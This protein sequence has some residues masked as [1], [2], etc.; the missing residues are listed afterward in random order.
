MKYASTIEFGLNKATP[1]KSDTDADTEFLENATFIHDMEAMLAAVVDEMLDTETP[2]MQ[3][4][5]DKKCSY[6]EFNLIC[7]RG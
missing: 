2:F 3:A 7:K 4:E 1:T 5:D 6:C